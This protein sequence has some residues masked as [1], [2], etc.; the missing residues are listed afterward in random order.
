MIIEIDLINP[1]DTKP[2]LEKKDEAK[3]EQLFREYQRQ[4]EL[5]LVIVEFDK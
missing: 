1:D 4:L 3:N 2:E 5:Q